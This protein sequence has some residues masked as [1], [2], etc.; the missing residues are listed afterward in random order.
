MR[1]LVLGPCQ[2]TASRPSATTRTFPTTQLQPFFDLAAFPE[3]RRVLKTQAAVIIDTDDPAA[4]RPRS[5]CSGPTAT[6]PW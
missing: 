6:G 3:S 2:R 1:D 4:D 5:P